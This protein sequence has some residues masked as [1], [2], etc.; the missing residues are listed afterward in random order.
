MDIIVR[1]GECNTLLEEDISKTE[2]ISCPK[3]GSFARHV[4]TYDS[5][6]VKLSVRE[7]TNTKLK[8]PGSRRP[9]K[10]VT[11]GDEYQRSKGKWAKLDRIIDREND[12]Y[13][14]KVVD[15]ETGEVY[16]ECNEPLSEH[17]NHG[18]AKKKADK[19]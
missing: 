10:E 19:G 1:C 4:E 12:K 16:H 17:I 5:E 3:C 15:P 2:R 6:E 14:E 9:I 18:S 13:H 7:Q 11:S 8:I